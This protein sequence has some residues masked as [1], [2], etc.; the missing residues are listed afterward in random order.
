MKPIDKPLLNDISDTARFVALLRALESDR[1]DAHF[2]DPYARKLA[3]EGAE[4]M[5][6]F[7]GKSYRFD[8]RIMAVRTRVIDELIL[9]SVYKEGV[10]LVLNLAAGLDTRPYRLE[11]PLSLHWVEVDFPGILA[12]KGHLMAAERPRCELETIPIDLKDRSGRNKLFEELNAT[13]RKVL[14]LTEGLLMY[15]PEEDVIQLA[16]DLSRQTNFGLWLMDLLSPEELKWIK[17]KF[18]KHFEEAKAR[19]Y[20]A[21]QEGADFFQPHGWSTIKFHSFEKEARRLNREA[22]LN[23]LLRWLSPIAPHGWVEKH[24]VKYGCAILRREEIAQFQS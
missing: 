3:G 4:K 14:I 16:Q 19:V 8:S 13:S 10:D 1:P 2:H 20:F 18:G 23:R 6:N 22:P 9:E 7:L 12:H 17:E 5:L 24:R 11:L 15:L 21:P